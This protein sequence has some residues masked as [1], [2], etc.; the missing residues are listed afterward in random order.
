MAGNAFEDD[1]EY[2]LGTY[3]IQ[4]IFNP[5][6]LFGQP[7]LQNSPLLYSLK[8]DIK[9]V[10]AAKDNFDF[11][12]HYLTRQNLGPAID[13]TLVTKYPRFLNLIDT[14]MA[15]APPKL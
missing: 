13:V 10:R 12:L 2:E 1:M 4:I 5:N 15:T 7:F 11:E 9:M 3:D 14:S 6:S 8:F